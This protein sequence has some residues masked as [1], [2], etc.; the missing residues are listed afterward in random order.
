M[1]QELTVTPVDSE[2]IIESDLTN[3]QDENDSLRVDDEPVPEEVLGDF[4]WQPKEFPASVKEP[5]PTVCSFD[6][7]SDY[8]REIVDRQPELLP[9]HPIENIAVDDL[10]DADL[11]KMLKTWCKNV[12]IV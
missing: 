11:I 1:D 9:D 12:K 10:T 5:V 4:F 8:R 7:S 2:E 6:Y 3:E